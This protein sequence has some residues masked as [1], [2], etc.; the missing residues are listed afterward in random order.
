MYF[1]NGPFL[2][3]KTSTSE[4]NSEDLTQSD[5]YT[6]RTSTNNFTSHLKYSKLIFFHQQVQRTPWAG[7]E[8][9]PGRFVWERGC[10]GAL[11]SEQASWEK[12]TQR[13]VEFRRINRG[14]LRRGVARRLPLPSTL[15]ARHRSVQAWPGVQASTRCSCPLYTSTTIAT[16]TD[17]VHGTKQTSLNQFLSLKFY[18]FLPCVKCG[19]P[20]SVCACVWFKWR[21]KWV[22]FSS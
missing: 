18:V 13:T 7:S 1:Q 15:P 20:T 4:S 6:V 16:I 12:P 5:C 11:R 8:N 9:G 2:F 17:I 22:I 21:I 14:C 19:C 10:V 3:D